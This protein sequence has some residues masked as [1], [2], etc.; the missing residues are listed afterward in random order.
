M[1]YVFYQATILNLFDSIIQ[2]NGD[3]KKMMISPQKT[4]LIYEGTVKLM[5]EYYPPLNI[6][7]IN[8]SDEV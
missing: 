8:K 6:K 5:A 7:I 1:Q 3:K 2:I 4:E